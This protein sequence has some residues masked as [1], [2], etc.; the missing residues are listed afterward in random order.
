MDRGTWHAKG[1]RVAKSWTYL[2]RL[3]MYTQ[4]SDILKYSALGPV[5]NNIANSIIKGQKC[6]T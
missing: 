3:S 4:K 1:H 2:K 5:A 6:F